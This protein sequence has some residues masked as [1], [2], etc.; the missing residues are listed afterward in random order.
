MGLKFLSRSRAE[1]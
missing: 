1:R